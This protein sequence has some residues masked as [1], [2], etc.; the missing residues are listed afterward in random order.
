MQSTVA[1]DEYILNAEYYFRLVEFQELE[2]S[3][4]ASSDANRH[5]QVAIAFSIVAIAVSLIVGAI[6]LN[7]TIT[8]DYNQVNRMETKEAPVSQ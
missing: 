5:S 1:D 3:R 8:I 7:S 4:I 2:E 6:Q